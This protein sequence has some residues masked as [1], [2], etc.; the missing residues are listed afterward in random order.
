MVSNKALHNDSSKFD[1]VVTFFVSLL[2]LISTYIS[3]PVEKIYISG[4]L[5]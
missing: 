2:R 3:K 4:F 5:C 1:Q